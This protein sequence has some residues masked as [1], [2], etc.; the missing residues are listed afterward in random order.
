MGVAGER[1]TSGTLGATTMGGLMDR[2]VVRDG[3]P[4]LKD[5][6]VPMTMVWR[7]LEGG[8]T[9]SQ[10]AAGLD[11][12]AADVIAALAFAGLGDPLGPPLVR[13]EPQRPALGGAL[14]EPGLA[15]L[16]PGMG[17]PV[18]LALAAGILQ[19]LDFWEASHE[20]AQEAD[21][22]GESATAAYWHGIAHRREP[23][24][25]NAAY[26]FRRVGRHPIFGALGEAAR[27]L[28]DREDGPIPAAVARL[29]SGGD[30]DPSA[31]IS[32]CVGTV[33]GGEGEPLARRLQRIEMIAL[34][35]ASAS[36]VHS[37]PGTGAG[38]VRE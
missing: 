32:L 31:M 15:E 17:R 19:A 30:W 25:G 34:L 22:L 20:A 33:P 35:E 6:G 38:K 9:P 29:T 11:L 12:S 23:D 4:V 2:V 26:W 28:I 18:R 36:V 37:S 21:D 8:E 16:L 14:A 24:A 10:V 5:S 3:V 7:R 13:A 1:R 27:E